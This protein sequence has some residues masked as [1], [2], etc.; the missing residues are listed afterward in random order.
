MVS[1]SGMWAFQ[2]VHCSPISNTQPTSRIHIVWPLQELNLVISDLDLEEYQRYQEI[3]FLISSFHILTNTHQLLKP[4]DP[5]E[6]PLSQVL[7]EVQRAQRNSRSPKCAKKMNKSHFQYK[8]NESV[9]TVQ[10]TKRL[11]KNIGYR[12]FLRKLFKTVKYK[13]CFH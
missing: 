10:I 2:G 12:L 1:F 5:W 11:S 6:N 4:A 9:C 7:L 13:E 3:Q 8:W